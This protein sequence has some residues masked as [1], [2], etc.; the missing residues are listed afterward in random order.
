MKNEKTK[1]RLEVL[2]DKFELNPSMLNA[3]AVNVEMKKKQTQD[4]PERIVYCRDCG[5]SADISQRGVSETECAK[6]LSGDVKIR[7][8]KTN[9]RL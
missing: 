1:T 6:C 8:A 3:V 9:K 4:E 5:I 7:D 2:Q